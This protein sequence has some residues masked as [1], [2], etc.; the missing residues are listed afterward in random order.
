MTSIVILVEG[1]TEKALFPCIRAFLEKRLYGNMP[2]LVPSPCDGRLP[3]GEKLRRRVRHLLEDGNDAVI[4][5]TDVYTGS[6]E[7]TDAADAKRKM[8]QW[9][10]REK[11]FHPHVALH[12]FEAWLLPYWSQIQR[13][14]G[15]NRVSPATDP[16]TVNHGNPPAAVLAEIFRTGEKG[17]RYVKTRDA[18][19][20]LR[21]QDLAVAAEACAELRAFLNTILICS[22]GPPL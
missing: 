21:G 20:I 13:L 15:S 18:I 2:K 7:F 22:G 3:T 10:G 19:A 5:L 12:D 6:R 16:E 14:A 1:A 11:H 8:R 9:V 4:A 17:K